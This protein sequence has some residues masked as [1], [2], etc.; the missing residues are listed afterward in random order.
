M[1]M[2]EIKR[3]LQKHGPAKVGVI[4]VNLDCD[5]EVAAAAVDHMVMQGRIQVIEPG[6]ACSCSGCPGSC[7]SRVTERLYALK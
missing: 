4:A 5:K 2:S 6:D 1:I 7:P 3:F